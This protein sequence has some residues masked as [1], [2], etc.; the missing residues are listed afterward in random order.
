M[1]KT[2]RGARS[3][4]APARFVR[5]E[6]DLGG[7]FHQHDFRIAP[8][9]QQIESD[10]AAVPL[11]FKIDARISKTQLV[12]GHMIQKGWH[13]RIA[14]RHCIGF[15]TKVHAKTGFEKGKGRGRGPGLRRASNGIGRRAAVTF[16]DE[17]AKQFRQTAQVLVRRRFEHRGED[18]GRMT[19]KTVTREAERDHGIV[20]RPDRA[21]VIGNRI[22][23]RLAARERSNPP[24][25]ERVPAEQCLGDARRPLRR[26]DPRE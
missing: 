16:A 11:E 5:G 3:P 6:Q 22:K 4:A 7:S 8:P 23:A 17:A 18:L 24:P 14:E 15:M 13:Y 19:D 10:I 26:C 1:A 12:Q 9:A 20:M 25:A 2:S 21:V